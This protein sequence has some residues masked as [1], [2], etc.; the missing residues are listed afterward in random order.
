ML[1]E[2]IGAQEYERTVCL[3]EEAMAQMSRLLRQPLRTTIDSAEAEERCAGA[4]LADCTELDAY[5]T[6]ILMEMLPLEAF[7]IPFHSCVAWACSICYIEDGLVNLSR[8]GRLLSAVDVEF[9]D[10]NEEQAYLCRLINARL[11]PGQEGYF[12]GQVRE[13][14]HLRRIVRATSAVQ[15]I[16]GDPQRTYAEKV[17]EMTA[18]MRR[19]LKGQ[20]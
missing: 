3:V 19:A 15:E 10:R 6:P 4:M 7:S 11:L 13:A 18:I 9:C 14:A 1:G 5:S 16:A 2:T 12:A 20:D 8:V 17:T